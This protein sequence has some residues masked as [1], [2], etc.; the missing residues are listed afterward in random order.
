MSFEILLNKVTC[1][2]KHND[3]LY[4]NVPSTTSAG[5]PLHAVVNQLLG[6]IKPV[7]EYCI[8][9]YVKLQINKCLGSC[10]LLSYTQWVLPILV[11]EALTLQSFAHV[12]NNTKAGPDPN[13]CTQ[14]LTQ[15]PCNLRANTSTCCVVKNTC[16]NMI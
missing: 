5:S 4:D 15:C 11:Q 13:V 14:Q 8:F 7:F 9:F 16:L 10:C 12:L 6:L 3:N 2:W 1:K